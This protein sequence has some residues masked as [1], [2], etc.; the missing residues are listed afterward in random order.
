VYLVGILGVDLRWHYEQ[1][2]VF[3]DQGSAGYAAPSGSEIVTI[4]NVFKDQGSGGYTAPSGSETLK[5]SKYFIILFN[6]N[7]LFFLIRPSSIKSTM[8]LFLHIRGLKQDISAEILE[9]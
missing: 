4:S 6:L 5:I 3:K 9:Q 1:G 2:N 8:D 7:S